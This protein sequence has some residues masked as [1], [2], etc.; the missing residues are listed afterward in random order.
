MIDTRWIFPTFS[1]IGFYTQELVRHMAPLAQDHEFIL[2]FSSTDLRDRTMQR[3][4]LAGANHVRPEVVRDDVFSLAGQLRL[5]GLIRRHRPDLFF[6]PN[7]MIPYAAFPV[8]RT[9]RTVL[10]VTLHDL[11]PLVMPDHAP[12]ARKARFFPVFKRLMRETSRRAD[13]IL[14][15][16]ECSRR[17][18]LE[19]LE[20]PHRD[21]NRVVTIPEAAGDAFTPAETPRADPPE[22]LYVGRF[23]PYKNVPFLIRSFAQ[24]A[25]RHPT[26]TL[27]VIGEPDPRY[28]EARQEADRLQL[29]PRIHWQGYVDTEGLVE[30]YRKASV[31]VQPSRYEG[32]GL[33]V[34]EAMACGAPVVCTNVS[35]LPEVAGDAARMVAP[36][37]EAGLA[38]AVLDLLEHPDTAADLSRRSLA[39]AAEFSWEKA[40]RETLNTFERIV[41]AT[42]E[43]A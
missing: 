20:A 8:H 27:R 26:V 36:D 21:S 9:G 28:P 11:I 34:I 13:V 14:T 25:K 3:P 41:Y 23:D 43:T 31:V 33:P 22:L 24:I 19:Q 15:P 32:F 29:N 16:S 17:D 30:A 40:A 1:G 10:A 38:E 2:L 6:S 35:S 5:P 42:K 37:D 4:G 18:V 12:K 39:R 7:W